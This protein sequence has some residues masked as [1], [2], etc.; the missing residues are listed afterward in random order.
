MIPLLINQLQV[1][2]TQQ[3][4]QLMFASSSDTLKLSDS[5]ASTETLQLLR[6]QF[7]SF[8]IQTGKLCLQMKSKHHFLGDE[9]T[10][11]SL[12]SNPARGRGAET[13]SSL[14]IKYELQKK[15]HQTTSMSSEATASSL[16]LHI[17]PLLC[18]CTSIS[19]WEQ[20]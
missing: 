17:S 13:R 11:H 7:S 18:S 5:S 10:E 1:R 14:L 16:S 12:L 8:Q 19:L 15:T 6:T 20:M 3:R 2:T 9:Q 4:L